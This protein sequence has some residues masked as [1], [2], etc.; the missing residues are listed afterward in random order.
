MLSVYASLSLAV[1]AGILPLFLL[2]PLLKHRYSAKWGYLSWIAL[3]VCLLI[4]FGRMLPKTAPEMVIPLPRI[5]AMQSYHPAI[6]ADD[7][8]EAPSIKPQAVSVTQEKTER[9][10]SL[11]KWQEP[12]TFHIRLVPVLT[13]CWLTGILLFLSYYALSYAM[14]RKRLKKVKAETPDEGTLAVYHAAESAV[15]ARKKAE[16][17]LVDKLP[18]PMLIGYLR[19]KILLP[20]NLSKDPALEMI[21]RHELVHLKRNDLVFKL[22]A[23]LAN[24]I[25]WFNPAVFLLRRGM[26]TDCELSCDEEVLRNEEIGARI[27]YGETVLA[28]MRSAV[29]QNSAFTTYFISRKGTIK[30]RLQNILDNRMKKR[31]ALA[32]AVLLLVITA[33]SSMV[34][35]ADEMQT[36]DFCGT[37]QIPNGIT[38]VEEL[39]YDYCVNLYVDGELAGGARTLPYPCEAAIQKY[40]DVDSRETTEVSGLPAEKVTLK[41]FFNDDPVIQK[42]HHIYVMDAKQGITYDF[43][44]IENVAPEGTAEYLVSH[45]TMKPISYIL[46]PG[47]GFIKVDVDPEKKNEFLNDYDTVAKDFAVRYYEQSGNKAEFLPMED[48]LSLFLYSPNFKESRNFTDKIFYMQDGTCMQVRMAA[49]AVDKK[50]AYAVI[51]YRITKAEAQVE[52]INME[53]ADDSS[54]AVYMDDVLRDTPAI[55][56]NRVADFQAAVEEGTPATLDVL[57]SKKGDESKPAIWAKLVFDGTTT[58]LYRIVPDQN[59]LYHPYKMDGQGVVRIGG[60][61][62]VT[63]TLRTDVTNGVTDFLPGGI[64]SK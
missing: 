45:W 21:L 35:F 9:K 11:L 23:V 29:R 41:S 13:A 56:V 3:C 39:K 60:L 57:N 4:P 42:E 6:L 5:S 25:H 2:R 63:Y 36:A 19:P 31:G 17:L 12:R 51:G 40:L 33:A 52:P 30:M 50:Y 16:L 24:A 1:S 47:E 38:K 8:S 43:F 15:H 26:E 10:A 53:Q 48:T 34:A 61:C 46:D 22:L 55:G 14:L 20:K 37:I 58:A 59:G 62:T 18:S 27:D 44:D 54:T 64:E 7:V 49:F 28:V 32:L